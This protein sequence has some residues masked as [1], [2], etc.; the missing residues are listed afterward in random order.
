M[1]AAGL[2]EQTQHHRL[3]VLQRHGGQA[4]VDRAS[5]TLHREAAVLRQ[6]LFGDVQAAHQLQPRDQ[7]A[8]DAAAFD[9]LLLQDAVDAQTH[10]Q[11]FPRPVRCARPRR[12]RCTA[13]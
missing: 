12:A 3:A 11:Q 7:R 2:V 5:R 1:Q 9:A 10:A 6:A 8:G 4:H 13:S